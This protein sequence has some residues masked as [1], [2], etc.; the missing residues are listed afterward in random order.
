MG[1]CGQP[2]GQDR[3][4]GWSKGSSSQAPGGRAWK[5]KLGHTS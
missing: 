2:V 3:D 1:G 5:H 4:A